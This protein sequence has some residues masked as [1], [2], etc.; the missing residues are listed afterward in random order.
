MQ[1]YALGTGSLLAGAFSML[2]F[3]LGTV[4]LMLAFGLAAA[5]VPRRFLPVM[6]KASA[7]L[8]M[9]L[10]VVTFSRAATLAGIP[11]PSYDRAP[12]P[13]VFAA[14][15]AVAVKK[16]PLIVAKLGN[17]VQTVTTEFKD[18]YYVP[19]VVQAGLPLKWT[20]RVTARELNGCNNPVTVPSYG[21]T[22]K[23]VAGDNL[24]E[25]TPKKTGTIVY[26]CWMGMVSSRISVVSDLE[27][28]SAAPVAAA[29]ALP[30][31][32]AALGG[33]CAL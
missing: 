8:V 24:V 3:S 28:A 31:S 27:K 20:I 5:L 13:G 10:G 32:G 11:L 19:F 18:G 7:V 4:P 6:V 2:V 16:D 26:T 29:P 22:K 25:F 30:E 15:T 33:C 23:L 14:S 21:I 9:F 1:L 17:G 12:V